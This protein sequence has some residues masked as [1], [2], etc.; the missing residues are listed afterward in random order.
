MLLLTRLGKL[1]R[2]GVHPPR[3]IVPKQD[4]VWMPHAG[5]LCVGHHCRFHLATAVGKW[6]ISTVGEYVPPVNLAQLVAIHEG[7]AAAG[8]P[9]LDK[10]NEDVQDI[11]WCRKYETMVFQAV[12][13][14]EPCS[15]CPFVQSDGSDA[16]MAGYKTAAEAYAGHLKMCEKWAGFP[17]NGGDQ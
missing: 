8:V 6:L 16:D 15:C 11:G 3:L 7:G 14:P 1:L 2:P 4:W 10:P 9:P 13:N 5:H 12:R 17:D